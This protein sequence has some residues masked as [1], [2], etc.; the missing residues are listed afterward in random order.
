M[1]KNAI[2]LWCI[3]FPEEGIGALAV[4]VFPFGLSFPM[5][6]LATLTVLVTVLG[7]L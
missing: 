3:T 6:S 5:T 7:G 1:S 2:T 4:I